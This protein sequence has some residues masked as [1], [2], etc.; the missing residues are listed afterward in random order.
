[1]GRSD[2]YLFPSGVEV[3]TMVT[4]TPRQPAKGVV[5]TERP[6]NLQDKN[7]SAVF[8]VL[9]SNQ[10]G[11]IT[12]E[13]FDLI[14]RLVCDRFG[15]AVDSDTGRQ[16]CEGYEAW[17]N[18][19]R[20][21]LDVDGDGQITKAEFAAIYQGGHGD[22]QEYFSKHVGPVARIVAEMIDTDDDGYIDQDEYLTLLEA[23]T[24]QQAA[25]AGFRQLDTDGD[26]RVSVAEMQAGVE[27]VM[28]SNDPSAPG[29][30]MLIEH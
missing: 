9:D 2:R 26:G 4:P 30:S 21:D 17:W 22:P 16:V 19:L 20:E 23:I 15:V 29:T 7:L 12:A 25:L 27:Q 24:D 5:M 8:N 1:M 14:S 3:D 13:D 18:Q 11:S 28:L 10:D 6:Q